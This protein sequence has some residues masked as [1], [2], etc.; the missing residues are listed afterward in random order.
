[1]SCLN[2]LEQTHL[3]YSSI[4]V[5]VSWKSQTRRGLTFRHNLVL[6]QLC[7]SVVSSFHLGWIFRH[8][9]F[10][11][12]LSAPPPHPPKRDYSILFKEA[13]SRGGH[14]SN[15][16]SAQRSPQDQ[17]GHPFVVCWRCGHVFMVRCS[18]WLGC[19]V[20]MIDTFFEADH[21]IW[22]LSNQ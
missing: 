21:M 7:V 9:W 18:L 11:L 8:L 4:S 17:A 16:R 10:L 15:P 22:L 3:Q 20:K 6:E 12:L 14:K 13:W 5:V 2:V 19:P 1:M